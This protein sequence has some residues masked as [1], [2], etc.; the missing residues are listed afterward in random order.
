MYLDNVKFDNPEMTNNL[1]KI[2]GKGEI[3]I[4]E[5]DISLS[6]AIKNFYAWCIENK[7]QVNILYA[8]DKADFKYIQHFLH[9]DIVIAFF[10]T[11]RTTPVANPL[12]TYL[13]ETK[14]KLTIIE[15]C[16]DKPEFRYIPAELPHITAYD[17]MCDS[18]DMSDWDLEEKH[19]RT[20][21]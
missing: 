20:L 15:C 12:I 10:T 17:L 13:V 1:N 19:R 5:N 18:D 11:E 14:W 7:K 6:Y 3:I 4:L 16:I 2:I 21:K 8:I 9:P